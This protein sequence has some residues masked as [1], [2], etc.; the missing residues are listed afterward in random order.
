MRRIATLSFIA[1]SA[2]AL[3]ACGSSGPKSEE[4]VKQEISKIERPLPGQYKQSMKVTKFEMPGMGARELE[5]LKSQMAGTGQT[6]SFCITK[7][8]SDEGFKR[9]TK[10][11]EK[12]KC[13]YDR[14]DATGGRLDAKMTCETGQGMNMMVEISGTTTSEGSNMVIKMQQ[15]VSAPGNAMSQGKM[16]MTNIEMEVSN[17]RIG[18]CPA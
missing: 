15:S 4:Q 10:E 14:F 13:N 11:F 7:E 1:V 16:G 6:Q 17:S 8:M 5:Y 2:A 12:G 18:E 9:M 3:S